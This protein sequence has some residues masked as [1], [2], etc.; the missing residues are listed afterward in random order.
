MEIVSRVSSDG[1][2][3]FEVTASKIWEMQVRRKDTIGVVKLPV[4]IKRLLDDLEVIAAKV[5]V[6]AVK[7]NLVLLINFDETYA[8]SILL[9]ST[10]FKERESQY[11]D[12]ILDLEEKL[13]SHDRIVYKI[14]Y[15]IPE[16]L[17][18]AI[19]AQPKM[20]D[21]DMLPSEELIINSTDSEKT[22]EDAEES[23]IKMR[24]KM[25][26][27]NYDKINSLYKT[28]VKND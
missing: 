26:Q 17:K 19:A 4:G 14:G 25:I 13:S 27:V 10:T 5:R 20:Y 9:G 28:F 22:L 3:T 2:R 15:Q 18:K 21:G 12:D 24:N 23:R 7:H 16:R 6:T 11:L 1:I 8:K